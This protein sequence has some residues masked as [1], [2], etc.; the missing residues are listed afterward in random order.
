LG[1][2]AASGGNCHNAYAYQWQQSADGVNFT[3]I[4]DANGTSYTPTN[5]TAATHYRRKAVCG[6]ETAYSNSLVIY[7][8]LPPLQGGLITPAVQRVGF[9][10]AATTLTLS[11]VAGGNGTYT[12]QWQRSS[13]SSFADMINIEG[14]TA[15]GYTP[16]SNISGTTYYRVMVSD[17]GSTNYSFMAVVTVSP[18]LQPGHITPREYTIAP[19][20]SPGRLSATAARY[21]MCTGG[22]TYQWE[23]STDGFNY[24]GIAGAQGATYEAGVL[25]ATTWFR[26]K[27]VCGPETAYTAACKVSIGLVEAEN[28]NYITVRDFMRGGVTD[29]QTAAG[30]TEVR[31]VKENT[32]Y[33]DGLGR[34]VQ[35]VTTQG[36]NGGKDVV[37]SMIYDQ[38]G[39][40]AIQYLP[41]ISTTGDGKFK[42]NALAE[43]NGFYK[44][45]T[46]DESIYF[47]QTEFELSPL[48]R[49]LKVTGAGDSWTGADRGIE[50]SYRVNETLDEVCKWT[51]TD[52][53]VSGDFG[54]YRFIAYYPKGELLKT[55]ITDENNKQ[56]IEFKNREGKV[57]L[58][59]VQLTADAENGSGS[60]HAGWLCT[61]YIYDDRQ[62]LRCVIQPQGVSALQS[63]YWNVAADDG[64]ALYEQ[65]FRYEYD[66]RGRMI[67][68]KMPGA[69]P[70]YMVYDARDRM[71]M[72]Q[73][74]TMRTQGKWM[75][76]KYDNLNR[77]VETG[78]WTNSTAFTTHWE[79][80]RAATAYP[81]TTADYELLGKTHYDDYSNL[82]SGL[83]ASLYNSGYGNYLTA[84]AASP[85]HATPLTQSTAVKSMVTWTS[86]KV[87]GTAGQFLSTVNIYDDKAR[88]I[89]TQSIN[90]TGGLDVVTSQ[91]SFSGQVLRSHLKHQVL[92][93]ATQTYEVATKNTYDDQG[94]ITAVEKNL[95][96]SGWKRITA[97]TYD[98]LGRLKTKK[99][100]PGFNN[101]AG[102]ETL[103]Y[104]HN[105]RGWLL[106]MN[107]TYV[108]SIA[109]T[110]GSYFGFD[111]GYDKIAIGNP[112][113]YANAQYNGNI[114]GTMWKSR[115]D[116]QIRKYDFAYDAVNRLTAADF[117]QYNTSFNKNDGVDLSVSN[118]TYDGNGNILTM[119]QKG[120]KLNTSDHI[121]RLR[122]T[123]LPFSNKLLNVI[124]INNDPLTTL[125]DF[126]YTSSHLQKT[127]KDAW[128]QDPMAVNATAITDYSYDDNGNLIS[129]KNKDITS[130]TYNFLNLPQTITVNGKGQISY[131]YDATG[132]KLQK[133]VTETNAAVAYNNASYT[134]GITTTTSYLGDFVYESK[135]YSNTALSALG[136]T[137][138]LQFLGHEEGRIRYIAGNG[139]APAHFEYDYFI[140]D[141]LGNVRMLLTEEQQTDVYDAGMEVANR[142]Y[143]AT[144]FGEKVQTTEA[145]KPGG[146]DNDNNNQKVSAVN[147]IT[148][149]SRIGPG[150]ILKVMAG[151]KITAQTFAWYQPTD[152]DNSTTPGLTA[153]ISSLLG[154]LAPGIAGVAKGTAAEQVTNG[155]L[156]PGMENFLGTQ[157]PASGA[158]K[159]FLNWV[160]IDEEQFKMVSGGVTPVP[161]MTGTQQKQLLQANSGNAIEMTKNGYLYVFVSNE[162]RGHVYFDD[163]HLEHIRGPLLEETHYYPFGLIMAG[164]SSKAAGSL[165]NRRKFNDK[166]EQ[167]QEFS[168]GS[169]LE[170]TDFGARMYDHQIGRWHKPDPLAEVSRRW[171]PY[172]YSYNN[173]VRFIDVDGMIPGD[174]TKFNAVQGQGAA[175]IADK[176][177]KQLAAVL[178]TAGVG[179][180]Q[181][182]EVVNEYVANENG[183]SSVSNTSEPVESSSGNMSDLPHVSETTKTS[184]TTTVNVEVGADGALVQS[185]TANSSISF[186][187]NSSKSDNASSTVSAGGSVTVKINENV[188]AGGNASKAVT[189]GTAN[190][191]GTG[192]AVTTP[193]SSAQAPL[194]FKVSVT[195]TTTVT[196]INKNYDAMGAP[197]TSST[198]NTYST[199]KTTYSDSNKNSRIAV[200]RVGN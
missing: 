196:T 170:L 177:A 97:L 190:T 35:S 6:I 9:T 162:S 87:P 125:G 26:R 166:E 4:T 55:V 90:I 73:D 119:D 50:N 149:E 56:I 60:G 77:Q 79:N 100:A 61:Y 137:H 112:G 150:V 42:T 96:G 38:F 136:Y 194:M 133:V 199:T 129:D 169:G 115:G 65:C 141:H 132:N 124:D 153:V 151:D 57:I 152:M 142:S 160:L 99:L 172:S 165:A 52:P 18:P 63:Y 104:D 95:N 138:K 158:P 23:Q 69:A 58:K 37:Q 173:P 187:T 131:V 7:V 8:Y 98:A 16:P 27:V 62:Q 33:F 117:N 86:V 74:A 68:K 167:R 175:V 40:E 84:S 192:M 59:K 94:K 171:S 66:A 155:I 12:Y 75:V 163:I 93:G 31:E 25:L 46:P 195:T 122:Y 83:T 126:R 80:A 189:T 178:K 47:A 22:Y 71:V 19:N 5:M 67:M 118:I 101:S 123:Y 48:N 45:Q 181:A 144:L 103:S 184:T 143:E 39:R 85:D 34:P 14:A 176:D 107:R 43:L 157:S 147:G 156:Q 49:V 2:S 54:T 32:R 102:L 72:L 191:S 64:I 53:A 113:N 44:E 128:A 106:G 13:T 114:A 10:G 198:T 121:D 140:K 108:K 109:A 24:T 139:A 88:I 89:Q 130:I 182:T 36:S 15:T 28:L 127:S 145:N 1:G 164:I 116:L 82:P 110:A 179:S 148:A 20:T 105:I 70:V 92:G 183:A 3:D 135:S 159:A 81:N 185:S 134:T 168:D 78:L 180:T 146:F 174:S 111:L 161:V 91:Y 17:N 76:T 197:T 186:N 154:Q 51:V 200:I 11:G 120:L 193:G 30:I 41:F 21:G 188:S 29:Q